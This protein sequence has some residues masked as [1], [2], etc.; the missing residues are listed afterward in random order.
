VLHTALRVRPSAN[1]AVYA[2]A[3]PCWLPCAAISTPDARQSTDLTRAPELR[4]PFAPRY[5]RSRRTGAMGRRRRTSIY[6]RRGRPG[7]SCPNR[8][9]APRR[10]T[11]LAGTACR[12]RPRR[13]RPCPAGY[14]NG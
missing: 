10:N 9:Q 1:M 14:S 12:R 7:L 6:G 11:C 2:I 8:L 5:S 4:L 13:T 3:S